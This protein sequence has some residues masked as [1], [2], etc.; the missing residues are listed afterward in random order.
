MSTPDPTRKGS[1]GGHFWTMLIT[2]VLAIVLVPLLEP[3]IQPRV[4]R[5]AQSF[6]VP[7]AST[8]PPP[9]TQ[10]PT[11][12]PSPMV[13]SMP[14]P[15]TT[16]QLNEAAQPSLVR[17][18]RYQIGLSLGEPSS[19][20]A[21][22]FTL[23][24]VT[25]P[26][27]GTPTASPAPAVPSSTGGLRVLLRGRLVDIGAGIVYAVRDDKAY[28]LTSARVATG[29]AASTLWVTPAGSDTARQARVVGISHCDDLAILVVDDPSGLTPIRR[30]GMV[31]PN[32]P[33]QPARPTGVAIIPNAPSGAV[34]ATQQRLTFGRSADVRSGQEVMVLGFT[35]GDLGDDT[36]ASRPAIITG[37]VSAAGIA[38]QQ[39]PDLL[40]FAAP[41]GPEYA[42]GPVIDRYGKLIGI[43]TF[44]PLQGEGIAYAI[45]VNYALA[46]ADQLIQGNNLH[47]T[48]LSLEVRHALDGSL[49]TVVGQVQAG[50]P[51][52]LAGIQPGDTL[53]KL[54]SSP[55]W[56]AGNICTNLRQRQDGEQVTLAVQ[57]T[58]SGE[59]T[60]Q[61]LSF[62]LTIGQP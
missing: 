34:L 36:G 48:G 33:V 53:V 52:A 19:T 4:I 13:F 17:V 39:H 59:S 35:R 31:I 2:L 38:W 27:L 44:A 55:L 10:T 62:T 23:P 25:A 1:A 16:F 61:E 18:E 15:W 3:M 28:L 40:R 57:R 41:S 49:A 26:L 42:G 21:T 56:I 54:D 24:T 12:T 8:P 43:T 51:A 32:L 60:P 45:G 9:P 50:S 47:W 22:T 29:G 5:V 7:P 6:G 46:I 11:A 14:Q 20:T 58:I 37:I 30:P